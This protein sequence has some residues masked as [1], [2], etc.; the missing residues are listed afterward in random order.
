MPL[1]KTQLRRSP[2]SSPTHRDA[3]QTLRPLGRIAASP[4][5]GGYGGA[6]H[7]TSGSSI[8]RFLAVRLPPPLFMIRFR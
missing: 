6:V 3:A 8:D 7:R 4:I 2:Q 5:A 1:E